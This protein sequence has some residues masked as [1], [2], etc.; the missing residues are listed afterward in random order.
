MG[1]S[2]YKKN[3]IDYSIDPIIST[4]T[5]PVSF[6]VLATP[7]S[8]ITDDE[9]DTI[10]NVRDRSNNTGFATTNLNANERINIHVR[11]G[12]E[13]EV[14][15]IMMLG[16]NFGEIL[17][18]YREGGVE[19][20]RRT[21]TTMEPSAV[22]SSDTINTFMEIDKLSVDYIFIGG[23]NRFSRGLS[24]G[25][26]GQA[27]MNQLIMTEK[28]GEFEN[29]LLISKM[30]FDNVKKEQELITRKSRIVRFNQRSVFRLSKKNVVSRN[31][32]ELQ[33]KIFE[34]ND[35]VLVSLSGEGKRTF[36]RTGLRSGYKPEDIFLMSPKNE[37]M[38]NF[39]DG[40][41]NQG[42]SIDMDMVEIA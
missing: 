29:Q 42:M 25:Q 17:V 5:P 32:L 3:F 18:I 10:Q 28:I 26:E 31:D 19:R 2:I 15:N 20:L 39:N 37:Y 30:Q 33:E 6:E 21:I 12:S 41:F 22:S 36:I 1:I 23:S 27:Y 35:G 7:T 8:S 40:R 13:V 34:E 11:F 24:P 4:G 9:R 16:H 38:P 14:S